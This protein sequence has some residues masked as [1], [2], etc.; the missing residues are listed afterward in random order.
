VK[1]RFIRE[2]D[3]LRDND[4]VVVRGG[5]LDPDLVRTDALRNHSIYGTYGISVFAVRDATLDEL[6]QQPPLVRFEHLALMT[7]G[8]VRSAGLRLEPTGRNPRHFD[9]GFDDLDLGVARLCACEH[10]VVANPYHED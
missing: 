8:V 1:Q 7:V 3:E 4:I 9:I 6:A 10:R 2:G 5:E